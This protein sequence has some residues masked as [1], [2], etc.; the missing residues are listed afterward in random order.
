[1]Y[2]FYSWFPDG[3]VV[4]LAPTKPLVTQQVEACH[5]IMGIPEQDTA[6]LD[7]SVDAERRSAYWDEKRA[8]FCTPQVLENDIQ[9]GNF[10]Y[11]NRIVC[12]VFDEAHRATGNFSYNKIV[13][14]FF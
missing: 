5:N 3:C 12:V 10:R 14:I 6:H 2:N 9:S 13:S 4:F 11:P 1:M 8:F 7:G